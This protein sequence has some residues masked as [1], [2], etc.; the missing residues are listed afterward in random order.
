M[1]LDE[2]VRQLI[3][4]VASLKFQ[5]LGL[6][7]EIAALSERQAKKKGV[8]GVPVWEAYRA[9]YLRRYKFEPARNAKVNRNCSDIA[10]RIGKDAPAVAE[11]YVL[12]VNDPQWAR[13]NHP[14]GVLLMNAESIYS[15]W[16]QGGMKSMTAARTDE[17]RANNISASRA[18]LEKKHGGPGDQG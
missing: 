8:S 17:R 18:Y 13:L 7:G 15:M 14:I 5:I 3:N 16:K 1:T 10:A 6:Q 12:Q 9:A 4:D 2:K 11:F